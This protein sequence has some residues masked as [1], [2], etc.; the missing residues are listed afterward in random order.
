MKPQASIL[1]NKDASESSAKGAL[2]ALITSARILASDPTVDSVLE[3]FSKIKDLETDIR[4]KDERVE[5]LLADMKKM[6]A[7]HDTTHRKAL[8]NYDASRDRLKLQVESSEEHVVSLQNELK[9]KVAA[10]AA[11]RDNEVSMTDKIEGLSM[12]AKLQD[13]E[14]KK[15]GVKIRA[16][17]ESLEMGKEANE[18]L[19]KA[20]QQQG[21]E[22]ARSKAALARLQD[23]YE[24]L[25]KEHR[26]IA[27]QWQV[28]QSLTVSLH[29]QDLESM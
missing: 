25:S 4:S 14:A 24:K 5:T 12:S 21:H 18:Q 23:D 11:L 15:T 29:E 26:S 20:H 27:Q 13:E 7:N 3:R 9:E 16:L 2:E 1:Q 8:S 22:L 10:I 17:E 19:K 6:V 28:A